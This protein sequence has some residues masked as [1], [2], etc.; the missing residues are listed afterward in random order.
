MRRKGVTT[1]D[2]QRKE[3]L[4]ERIDACPFNRQNGIRAVQAEDG[5]AVVTV[6]LTHE[7]MNIWGIP[8]GGLLF[9]LGDVASGLATQSVYEGTAVSVS[10]TMDFLTAA[11]GAESLTAVGTVTK[12]GRTMAFVRVEISDDGGRSIA[13]GQYVMHLS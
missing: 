9:S 7:S 10:G 4:L 11:R 5:R 2:E 1:L 3:F 8:H 6:A 13:A 12:R